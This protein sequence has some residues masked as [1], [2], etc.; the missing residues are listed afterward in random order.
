MLSGLV[1]VG[2]RR[3]RRYGRRHAQRRHPGEGQAGG[4]AAAGQ[5]Q[6]GHEG[7]EPQQCPYHLLN[8]RIAGLSA[9]R[10]GMVG[11]GEWEPL[12]G[13]ETWRP[14]RAILEDPARKPR[15]EYGRFWLGSR[16]ARGNVVTGIGRDFGHHIYRCA[17]A[18]RTTRMRAGDVARQAAPVEDFIERI[19]IART[20][21]RGR[22]GSG[23]PPRAWGGRGR[24]A[25]GGGSDPRQPGGDGR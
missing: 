12:V 15:A 5:D 4:T 23:R 9:Y 6:A 19:V 13:E 21:P 16:A 1:D 11:V 14:V 10:E 17:P 3:A 20:V 7:V 25:R 18:T 22:S 24:A 2:F 8:P